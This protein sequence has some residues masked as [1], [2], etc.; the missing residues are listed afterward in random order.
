MPSR[1]ATRNGPS[2]GGTAGPAALVRRWAS[3]VKFWTFPIGVI[4]VTVGAALYPSG[5]S[6]FFYVLM[7]SG[8][9]SLNFSA[10]M[11]NDLFDFRHGVDKRTDIAVMRRVHPLISGNATQSKLAAAAILLIVIASLCGAYIFLLRGMPILAAGLAGILSAVFY[12]AGRENVK[13]TGL[14]EL[15]VFAVYGPII[16]ASAYFV[17]AGTLSYAA[18]AASLPVGIVISM[19]LLANNIRDIKSDSDAGLSTLPVRL[20]PIRAKLLFRSMAVAAY[21]SV[22]L[23]SALG[24]I[25]LFSLV[26][27]ASIPYAGSLIGAV[28]SPR[29]AP[30]NSAELGSRFAIAFGALLVLGFL[31]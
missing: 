3:I 25:P 16:T 8:V 9:V 29:K 26:T 1:K 21:A 11:L 6:P 10:N 17:E 23:F 24:V 30:P 5:F 27:L 31:L 13:S 20:G 19:I 2:P 15:L 12:T 14:G 18:L 28:A 22:I 7:V 4:P